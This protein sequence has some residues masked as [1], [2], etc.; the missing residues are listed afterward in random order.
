M[1]VNLIWS[2]VN[3][4]N[5]ITDFVDHGN[6]S[7]GVDSPGI[8]IFIRHD[9]ENDITGVAFFLREFTGTY[10]G[11]A[12]SNADFV[13]MLGWGDANTPSTFGGV[14]IN[15]DAVGSYALPWPAYDD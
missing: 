15:W 8:Q 9:G 1:S 12:T 7:N 5:A 11:D 4:D 10:N 2:Y 13:E 6:I 3:G 14:A